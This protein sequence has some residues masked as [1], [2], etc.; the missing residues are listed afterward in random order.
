MMLSMIT[1]NYSKSTEWTNN[2]LYSYVKLNEGADAAVVS[3]SMLDMSDRHVGPEIEMYLGITLEEWRATGN[4][5]YAYHMQPM[6]D[7]RL[8]S[9]VD[10]NI[11]AAGDITYVYLLSAVSIFYY[12]NCLYQFHELVNSQ[13]Y[14]PS[15]RSR[16]KKV[17]GASV[18][19][20]VMALSADFIKLL[21]YASIITVPIAYFMFD[22]LFL[23]MQH[24]RANIGVIEIFVSIL[25]LFAI[26]FA[27]V[28]S[29]TVRAARKNPVDT[30]RY[31]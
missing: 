13:S 16:H 14:W 6:T 23:R 24:F 19:Q 5:E 28:M 20:L 12:S 22:K 26:G 30:L 21:L 7:I 25:A 8:Y 31:E 17:M 2:S 11:D 1:W 4:G 15:Q 29:Q 3:A 27:T 10:G 18:L 9:K